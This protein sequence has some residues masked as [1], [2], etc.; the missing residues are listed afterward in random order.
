MLLISSPAGPGHREALVFDAEVARR[1]VPPGR[2]ETEGAEPVVHLSPKNP[3][4]AGNV[5]GFPS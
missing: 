2:E 3:D 1:A 4:A 5:V